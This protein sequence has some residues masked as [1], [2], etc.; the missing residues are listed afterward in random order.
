LSLQNPLLNEAPVG[1]PNS[2]PENFIFLGQVIQVRVAEG[3]SPEHF[4][5][6]ELLQSSIVSLAPE[7]KEGAQVRCR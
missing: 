5:T 3:V 2:S 7:C 6:K 1:R 4:R